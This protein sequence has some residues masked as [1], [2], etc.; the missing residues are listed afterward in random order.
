MIKVWTVVPCGRPTTERENT[1]LES[2]LMRIE[3]N[4]AA[5]FMKFADL[6]CADFF[7]WRC[8]ILFWLLRT[9]KLASYLRPSNYFILSINC[10]EFHCILIIPLGS[11]LS[12][13][14]GTAP[15]VTF[16][17]SSRIAA[18][19]LENSPIVALLS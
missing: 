18:Y 1:K 14:T 3:V 9:I 8:E 6:N 16:H 17:I 4:W 19:H 10:L 5:E 11:W 7:Y 13:N 12:M 2:D 15:F